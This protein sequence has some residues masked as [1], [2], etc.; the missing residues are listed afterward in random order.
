MAVL[1]ADT[2]VTMCRRPESGLDR[3]ETRQELEKGGW[4]GVEGGRKE[5]RK[6]VARNEGYLLAKWDVNCSHVH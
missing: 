6:E 4:I 3:Q 2:R 5:G 1:V